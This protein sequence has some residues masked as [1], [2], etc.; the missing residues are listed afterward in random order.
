MAEYANALID[1]PKTP[2][3][4]ENEDQL[5]DQEIQK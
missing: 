4:L 3:D 2:I 5:T 1:K